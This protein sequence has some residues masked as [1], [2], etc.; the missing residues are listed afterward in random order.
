[1]RVCV[2]PQ[3]GGGADAPSVQGDDMPEDADA[4]AHATGTTES[5]FKRG[6]LFKKLYRLLSSPVVRLKPLVAKLQPRAAPSEAAFQVDACGAR[7]P[8]CMR[9]VQAPMEDYKKKSMGIALAICVIQ[10]AAFL[11]MFIL[12]RA[13]ESRVNDLKHIGGSC[14]AALTVPLWSCPS[15]SQTSVLL[16]HVPIKAERWLW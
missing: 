5:D 7:A 11:A 10:L 14:Q 9:Q 3:S 12:Q 15:S 6:A 8:V 13:Q 1:M 16:M 2:R 4:A